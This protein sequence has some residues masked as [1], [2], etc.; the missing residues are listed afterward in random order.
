MKTKCQFFDFWSSF[1]HSLSILIEIADMKDVFTYGLIILL[2]YFISGQSDA[3]YM[4]AGDSDIL[5]NEVI[6]EPSFNTFKSENSLSIYPKVIKEAQVF[7]LYFDHV[8]DGPY[9]VELKDSNGE[10]VEVIYNSKLSVFKAKSSMNLEVNTPLD[11]GMYH[12]VLYSQNFSQA[13]KMI[14]FGETKENQ[15]DDLDLSF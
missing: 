1:C 9:Y 8:I 6:L 2:P 3:N 7:V 10:T 12:V 11:P 14:K 4:L 13:T 5:K 15:T